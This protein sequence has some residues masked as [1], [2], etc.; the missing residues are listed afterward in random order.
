MNY[1]GVHQALTWFS[2]I[3]CPI[4]STVTEVVSCVFMRSKAPP[5]LLILNWFLK[6]NK[7]IRR[8]YTRFRRQT[9]VQ[10]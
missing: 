6:I 9:V 10:M 3:V 8:L 1:G 5:G 2:L 4:T 7:M